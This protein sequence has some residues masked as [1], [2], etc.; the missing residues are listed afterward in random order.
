MVQREEI[1]FGGILVVARLM[2]NT[3]KIR[4][5]VV[6][7]DEMNSRGDGGWKIKGFLVLPILSPVRRKL[8]K[9][10]AGDAQVAALIAVGR[11]ESIS[12]K[13]FL[14]SL[15]RAPHRL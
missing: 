7:E 5:D 11:D 10:G 14:M 12:R 2:E 6:V 1:V 15:G 3:W 8:C 9:A 13:H 4:A